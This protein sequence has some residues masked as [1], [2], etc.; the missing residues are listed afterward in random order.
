[1]KMKE[2]FNYAKSSLGINFISGLGI[3]SYLK[4]T[5]MAMNISERETVGSY[6]VQ[7][8][9]VTTKDEKNTNANDSL[10]LTT[11]SLGFGYLF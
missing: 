11:A 4:V 1:M 9:A 5:M 2:K 7:S 10:N 3:F 6:K 8:G